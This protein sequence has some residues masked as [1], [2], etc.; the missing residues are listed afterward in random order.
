MHRDVQANCD[1]LQGTTTGKCEVIG[2]GLNAKELLDNDQL[3][4]FFVQ[5]LNDRPDGWTIPDSSLD[6][7]VCCV[8]YAY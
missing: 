7:V 6:A 5:N 3:D 8:R 1:S 2:H 4:R